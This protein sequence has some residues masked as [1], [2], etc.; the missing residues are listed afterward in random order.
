MMMY[1]GKKSTAEQIMYEAMASMEDRAKQEALK[2]FKAA[3]DNCKLGPTDGTAMR[4][5]HAAMRLSGPILA[6]IRARAAGR[7]LSWLVS[8]SRVQISCTGRF[9][10]C[11]I[12]AACTQPAAI[13]R[14]VV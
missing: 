12:S 9:T 10:S 14:I 3:V 6:R 7:Y 5:G 4:P 11:A 1:G 13:V 2:L 8:S